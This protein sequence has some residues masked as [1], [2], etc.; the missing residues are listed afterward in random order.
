MF[1]IDES[2][3]E[4]LKK[5]VYLEPEKDKERRD[6][7]FEN[8]NNKYGLADLLPKTEKKIEV[9]KELFEYDQRDIERTAEELQKRQATLLK[10][11]EKNKQISQKKK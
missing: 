1:L 10:L 9:C 2:I 8:I 11:K 4:E 6:K 5:Y 7:L 3:E